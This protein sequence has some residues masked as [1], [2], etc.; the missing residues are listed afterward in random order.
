MRKLTKDEPSLH[1][2]CNVG[3]HLSKRA[4]VGGQL[5][6]VVDVFEGRR[7]TFAQ[8][9]QR[10]N[11][12]AHAMFSLGLVAGDRVAVLLPNGYRYVEIYY[13]AARAGIILVPLNLRLVTDEVAFILRDAG[14]SALIACESHADIVADLQART[15]GAALAIQHWIAVFPCSMPGV[16]DY[17]RLLD[18]ASSAPVESSAGDDDP[19]FIMYT[20]GTTGRPKG[21][22]Q[23]HNSIQWSLLTVVMSTDMRYRDRYLI[24][25]P[26][27][28][29]AAFNN[30]GTTL[31]RGGVI[32]ILQKFDAAETWRTLRDERINITLAV[33]AMLAALL[34]TYDAEQHRPLALRW[35]LSGAQAMPLPLLKI[36]QAMGFEIYQAY[37]LTEAGGVGCCM[38]PDDAATHPTSIG[39]GFFHTEVRVVDPAGRECAPGIAGELLIRGKHVM[40]EYWQQPAQTAETIRNGWLHT[41]DVAEKDADGFLY[42]RDRLK[43]MI[44]SGGENIYPAEI[45]AIL[46]AHPLIADVSVIGVPSAKWGES[47]MAVVVRREGQLDEAAVRAYCEGKIA[48]FKLPKFVRF[49]DAIPRN[50]TGKALK[51]VL[52]QQFADAAGE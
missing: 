36:F 9:N 26:M 27:Y 39:K 5:E 44:I 1:A 7:F 23:T 41:G 24:S 22:V 32:V 37:G 19:M 35:I 20:S 34:A 8:M 4:E 2:R 10:A 29:I 12:F 49:I 43:D 45:E 38:S 46:I 15:S 25:M 30:M 18:A 31:Y 6:A 16:L 42:I 40:Q 28:H 50:A 51:R 17:D 14:V 52:R 48:R 3:S 47:P 13:G 11:R 21:T 33:P